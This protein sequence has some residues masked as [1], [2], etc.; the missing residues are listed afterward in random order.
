MT[1]LKKINILSM[2]KFHT[3][4]SGFFGLLAGVLYSFGG[5]VI[6]SLVTMGFVSPAAASTSGLSYGTVL[7]FGA[8]IGMPLIFATVGFVIGLIQALLYNLFAK[9]FGGIEIEIE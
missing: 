3:F 6:D 1:V 7:A 4:F 2:A 9:W 8:L 5:L